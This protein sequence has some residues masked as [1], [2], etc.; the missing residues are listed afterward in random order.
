MRAVCSKCCLTARLWC[1]FK[2]NHTN[3]GA[4]TLNV[5]SLGAVALRKQVDEAWL[6]A[7]IKDPKSKVDNAK[8]PKL[9]L[10]DDEINAVVTYLG[11]LKK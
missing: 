5:N 3:T 11:T 9:P 2:A 7:Y 10:S 8:M 1:A 4:A 6:K